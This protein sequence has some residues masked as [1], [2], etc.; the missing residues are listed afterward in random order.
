ML[1]AAVG[2][3]WVAARS[4]SVE[5]APDAGTVMALA[6]AFD[7]QAVTQDAD[8][9]APDSGP[10]VVVIALSDPDEPTVADSGV[11]ESASALHLG[12]LALSCNVTCEA[13]LDARPPVSLPERVTSVTPGPHRVRFI[14]RTRWGTSTKVVEFTLK[15]DEA[16]FVGMKF[17]TGTLA[18]TAPAKSA[19][20]IFGKR[21]GF[22]PIKALALI[23][24]T[25]EL[26]VARAGE[27]KARYTVT[28]VAGKPT[29]LS[30]R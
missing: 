6:P 22:T 29:A 19:V 26:L 4:E 10:E 23:E 18:V 11:V 15:P 7:S 13:V 9:T 1:V 8:A 27:G 21:V 16:K 30:A 2:A 17:G 28:I 3:V 12:E 14:A 24:G 20:F 25:H 5:S